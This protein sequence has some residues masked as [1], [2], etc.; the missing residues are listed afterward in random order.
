MKLL[1]NENI[2]RDVLTEA[3]SQL[4]LERN[5]KTFYEYFIHQYLS[6]FG[7]TRG[8]LPDCTSEELIK[9][10]DRGIKLAYKWASQKNYTR[11]IIHFI[12]H[13][14]RNLLPKLTI[15][16]HGLIYIE[17]QMRFFKDYNFNKMSYKSVGECW[18]WQ[19]NNSS[20]YCFDHD[21]NDKV[22][23]IVLHGYIHPKD[24]DW[25]ETLYI[26][27]YH[28]SN[29]TELRTA[30]GA[31]VELTN[32]TCEG[33]LIELNQSIL[34]NAEPVK[35]YHDY[36]N[37]DMGLINNISLSDNLSIKSLLDK[38][39]NILDIVDNTALNKDWY[40]ITH[41][42]KNNLYNQTEN[43]VLFGDITDENTWPKYDIITF[44]SYRNRVLLRYN[45]KLNIYDLEKRD[46]IIGELNNINTWANDIKLIRNC[47]I[48]L[49]D[50]F[51]NIYDLQLNKMIFNVWLSTVKDIHNGK[52]IIGIHHYNGIYFK[53]NIYD[54]NT[55]KVLYGNIN[56]PET[57]FDEMTLP[58]TKNNP[59][60]LIR[61][62]QKWN[63]WFYWS[64]SLIYGDINNPETWFDW[65][66]DIYILNNNYKNMYIKLFKNNKKTIYNLVNKKITYGDIDDPETWFDRIDSPTN[67]LW[68]RVKNN[69]LWNYFNPVRGLLL[70][71]WVSQEEIKQINPDKYIQDNKQLAEMVNRL[72][73][74]YRK[75]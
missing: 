65:I 56:N 33:K 23:T 3:V 44:I 21:V 49:Q 75:Y 37:N 64:N 11:N 60:S 55:N 54:I 32:I 46:V 31:K 39:C 2:Y 28:M 41:N 9:Y 38:G 73:R 4:L 58:T 1:F 70:N 14:Q 6:R 63:Y 12:K 47:C 67:N 35:Y 17:R 68:F 20:A 16:E 22:K 5:D 42:N 34:V 26:N 29:E 27:I 48:I 53:E 25:V 13:F 59:Y 24:V 7:G 8:K 51:Y 45:N 30:S 43:K 19:H 72:V 74:N 15:N 18:S 36:N 69:E 71:Q 40:I 52:L 61:V 62:G 66:T 50:R 57:W 10:A